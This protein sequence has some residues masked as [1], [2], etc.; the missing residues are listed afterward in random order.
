MKAI[1]V[2]EDLPLNSSNN[3]RNLNLEWNSVNNN[4]SFKINS[5]N[6]NYK[7]GYSSKTNF[8]IKV[9]P[10]GL[11]V[12]NKINF[13]ESKNA[14]WGFNAH[15][16][17]TT[18]MILPYK[19]YFTIKGGEIAYLGDLICFNHKSYK[20][21]LIPLADSIH[22]KFY[23]FLYLNNNYEEAKNIINSLFPE[24]KNIEVQKRLLTSPIIKH[25][26]ISFDDS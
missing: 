12:L 17:H 14:I 2:Q 10:A 24:L 7:I 8:Y 5:S 16:K 22:D 25:I 26:Y 18:Y 9:I 1:T 4:Y 21:E 13:E 20:K 15:S 23:D 11:Y 6:L 3:Y 19:I